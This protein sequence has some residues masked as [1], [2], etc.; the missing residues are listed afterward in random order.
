MIIEICCWSQIDSVKNVSLCWSIPYHACIRVVN[1]LQCLKVILHPGVQYDRIFKLFWN[2]F[3]SLC[4][5]VV[6]QIYLVWIKGQF[7]TWL[8]RSQLLG[9]DS[10]CFSFLVYR[11]RAWITLGRL[12][13]R[14]LSRVLMQSM[15]YSGT[16]LCAFPLT[17]TGTEH[18]LLWDDSVCVSTLVYWWVYTNNY[19]I[20]YLM[21]TIVEPSSKHNVSDCIS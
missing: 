7:L 12:C 19:I 3:S 13:V 4:D 6:L 9:E 21:R 8:T 1:I 5:P 10:V 17:C 16:T 14:F 20:L 18:E 11:C 2:S 15:N